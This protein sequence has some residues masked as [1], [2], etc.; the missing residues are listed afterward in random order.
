MDRV[1]IW[2]VVDSKPGEEDEVE[3]FLKS[4]LALAEEEAETTRW[5][6]VRIGPSKFGIF[7][8]FPDERG[9]VAHLTGEI[10]KALAAK[11]P[12]LFVR[13]PEIYRLSI[14]ASKT[15]QGSMTSAGQNH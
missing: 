7:D 2:A 13:E 12:D 5:Y 14:L 9:R 15:P 10:A 4:A 6:A 1:A 8:T 3:G 11:A